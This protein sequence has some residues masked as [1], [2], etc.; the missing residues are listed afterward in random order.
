MD[1]LKSGRDSTGQ[2]QNDDE[3]CRYIFNKFTPLFMGKP[4]QPKVEYPQPK[5]HIRRTNEA[6]FETEKE[7]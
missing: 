4:G 7:L 2:F 5:E 3:A 6:M 1:K